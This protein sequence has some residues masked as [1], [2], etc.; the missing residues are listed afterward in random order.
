MSGDRRDSTARK[1]Y[2]SQ[3]ALYNVAKIKD[4]S[5][6]S[7]TSQGKCNN[8]DFSDGVN[9]ISL[10]GL[11]VNIEEIRASLKSN[12]FKMASSRESRFFVS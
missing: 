12:C 7:F 9:L 5:S 8:T 3:A 2:W 6:N 11:A 4:I 10:V 1:P